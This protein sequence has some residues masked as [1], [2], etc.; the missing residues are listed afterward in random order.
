MA[1]RAERYREMAEA[2]NEVSIALAEAGDLG[3]QSSELKALLEDG[4]PYARGLREEAIKVS[5]EENA[6]PSVDVL[7]IDRVLTLVRGSMDRLD[8][9]LAV[10]I[11]DEPGTGREVDAAKAKQIRKDALAELEKAKPTKPKAR[12]LSTL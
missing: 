10:I 12:R 1:S 8:S 7:E 6:P 9:S 3:I 5:D 4:V 2:A 11:T